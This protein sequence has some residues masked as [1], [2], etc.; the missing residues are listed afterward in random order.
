M[1]KFRYKLLKDGKLAL[2]ASR[3]NWHVIDSEHYCVEPLLRRNSRGNLFYS[4][5]SE[6]TIAISCRDNEITPGYKENTVSIQ[7]QRMQCIYMSNVLMRVT[8]YRIQS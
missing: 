2:K 5:N 6:D 1:H 8:C 4:G 3:Y 7:V